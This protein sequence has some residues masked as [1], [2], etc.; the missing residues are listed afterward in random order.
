MRRLLRAIKPFVT[1]WVLLSIAAGG[2]ELA[3]RLRESGAGG[4][5]NCLTAPCRLAHHRLAPL[6][7][8]VV[9]G[10]QT[11]DAVEIAVNS[12]GLRGAEVAVPKPPGVYR[13]LC[14]GDETVLGPCV[15]EPKTLPARLSARLQPRTGVRLEVL[16]AG[17]PGDCPLLMWL[18]LRHSLL[19][20]QPDLVIVHVDMTDPADDRRYRRCTRLGA[21]GSPVACPH[22]S[23]H[24]IGATRVW[25]QDLRLTRAV[26]RRLSVL[27]PAVPEGSAP[28]DE[29][30]AAS[31]WL[32]ESPADW[33]LY[34]EQAFSPLEEIR[35]AAEAVGGFTVVATAPQPWQ[36]S[37]DA[38]AGRGVREACGVAPGTAF[39]SRAPFEAVLGFAAAHGLP[40]C[41]ASPAFQ[42]A[43]SATELFLDHAPQL[44]PKGNDLYAIALAEFIAQRVA[45]FGG[46][47]ESAG[48]GQSESPGGGP[49]ANRPDGVTIT[50]GP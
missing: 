9:K 12:D 16:N 44:S 31:A 15:N 24:G 49:P 20:L 8:I 2:T 6:Q 25:W 29:P 36:V 39:T 14:L 42:A 46:S 41:D 18:R 17:V 1:A 28:I 43:P 40:C 27:G 30:T 22:P 13:V 10:P 50:S 32:R 21:S 37:A 34:V 7:Q 47:P 4:E 3:L 45:V 48:G 23:I 26:A 35:Q 5:T 33:S 38:C 11:G 19:A